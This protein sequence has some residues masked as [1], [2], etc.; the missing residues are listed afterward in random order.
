MS[1]TRTLQAGVCAVAIALPAQAAPC[2]QPAVK[3]GFDLHAYQSRLMVVALTCRDEGGAESGYNHLVR[4]FQ[5][6]LKRAYDH[7]IGHFRSNGGNRR[8]DDYVTNL[9]NTQAQENISQGDHLCRNYASLWQ[10]ISAV[11]SI[12]DLVTLAG[13]AP[14]QGFYPLE[15]CQPRPQRQPARQRQAAAPQRHAAAQ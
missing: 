15:V 4:T 6:D 2:V 3:A 14:Q 5:R 1:F 7:V 12:A 10:Q 11:T 9:A 13:A 8:F